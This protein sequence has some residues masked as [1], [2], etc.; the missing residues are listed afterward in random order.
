[1]R[2][3]AAGR[4]A[5]KTTDLRVQALGAKGSILDQEKMPMFMRKG[6]VSTAAAREDKRRREARENGIILE[7]EVKK[8]KTSKKKGRGDRPVDLP[9]VGRMRGAELRVSAREAKAIAASVKRPA[10]RRKKKRR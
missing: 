6:I 10:E 3:F 7:R 8:A 2:A 5:R 4:T 9:A 1:M